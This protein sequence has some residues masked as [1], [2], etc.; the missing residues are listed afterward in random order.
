MNYVVIDLEFNGRKHYDVRPMEIIEIGAVKL[1]E[2]LEITD[3]FQ[4]YIRPNF[5]INRF[6]LQF[7][8]ISKETLLESDSFAEVIG[9]FQQF[10]GESCKLFAW[11]AGD[12]FHL[13]VDCKVN[14]LSSAWLDKLVDLTRFFEGGLQQALVDHQL[15]AI[16]Q[17]H[18]ALDDALNAVQLL[19]HQP[20]IIQSNQYFAPDPFKLCTGGIKKRIMLCVDEAI[21]QNKVLAWSEF[22]T[23]AQTRQ[24]F[25]VM[26]LTEDEIRLVEQ[27]FIKLSNM[28]YGRKWKKLQTT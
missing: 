11:G 22:K 24:Y 10:C 15:E 20:E 27:L 16:G 18:S 17:H 9:R 14:R 13:F 4:S 25:K 19:K 26:H 6:A 3:T 7:C 12:F 5:P 2:Q 23:D 28:K 21:A 8:G 1:N